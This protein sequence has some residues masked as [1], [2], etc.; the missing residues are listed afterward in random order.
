MKEEQAPNR[1]LLWGM[2][3]PVKKYNRELRDLIIAG[4]AKPS[5]I[6]SHHIN[7]DH[8]PDAYKQFDT[9]GNGYTKVLIQFK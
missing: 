5:S 7:I 2:Q 1:V 8:A 6:V 9:R 4:K 3:T